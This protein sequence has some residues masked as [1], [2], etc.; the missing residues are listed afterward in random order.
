MAKTK[1]RVKVPK[2]IKKGEVFQVKTLISH[3]METGQRKNKKTGKKISRMIINKLVCQ[4]N[5]K[6]VF[7]S[8]WHPAISANPYM[9]FYVKADASGSLDFTWTDDEGKSVKKSAKITVAG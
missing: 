5:G 9:A 7:A 2:S 8:D 1:A 6:E 3:K 4:Y